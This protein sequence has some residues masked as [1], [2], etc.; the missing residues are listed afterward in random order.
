MACKTIK[1]K[2]IAFIG[3]GNM[4]FACISG[5]LS[6]SFLLAENFYIY[7]VDKSKYDNYIMQN[8]NKCENVDEAVEAADIIVLAVKP[9]H[10]ES[11]LTSIKNAAVNAE[12]KKVFVSFAAGVSTQYIVSKLGYNAPVVRTMPNT[13]FLIGKGTMA[14]AKNEFADK[15]DFEIVCSIFAYIASVTAL[16]ESMMNKVIALN[17]SSPAYVFRFF[18]AMMD[19]AEAEGFSEKE[20]REL[21]LSTFEGSVAMLSKYPDT[22][23]LIKNVTSPNGTTQASMESLDKDDFQ[24]VIARCMDCCTRRANELADSL[25]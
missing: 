17:G 25:S 23:Q 19:A 7:D 24:N 2:K 21:I 4:A 10:M 1:N 20:S 16:D 9:Q 14:A 11:A 13:P 22:K 15:N 8:I 5:L 12:K 6:A 3:A 18:D